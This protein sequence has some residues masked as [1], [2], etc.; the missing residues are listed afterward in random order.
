MQVESYFG[1]R[2]ASPL[3]L[4]IFILA[5]SFPAFAQDNDVIT[6]DTPLVIMN[7]TVTDKEGRPALGLKKEQFEVTERGTRQEIEIFE[8][9]ETPFAAV[10]LIDTSGSMEQRVSL[11]RAAAIKFLDGIRPDDQ[12][13]IYNFDSRLSLVQDFSNL[14]DLMPAGFDLKASG[15]TALNDAVFNAAEELSKRNEKRKAIIVLSDGADTRSGKSA[16]KA[17]D[18][19]LE[20]NATIYT[21]DMSGLNTGGSARMQNRGVLKKFANRTG[22]R[23]IETP[24]GVQMRQ[25]F[26]NI[27]EELGIQYTIGYYPTDNTRDGKWRE[28]ELKVSPD[29]LDVRTR[30][31]YN[32]PSK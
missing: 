8:T 31:G 10:I 4:S 30:K 6:I 7:A 14:R 21:V 18:A 2:S 16:S 28:I 1:R 25:A 29:S 32:A 17:L 15:W 24:G 26:E 12:V 20:A 9:Q 11:A 13:A 22:G 27:V 19:A 3:L 5:L 23:F